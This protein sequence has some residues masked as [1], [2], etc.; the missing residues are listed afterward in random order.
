MKVFVRSSD[1]ASGEK[2]PVVAYYDD[3]SPVTA[4]AHGAGITVISI[5]PQL[6]MHERIEGE[7][8][9][10]FGTAFLSPDW[11][12]HAGPE[13]MRGEARRRA[14]MVLPPE[15]RLIA[16]YELINLMLAHGADAARWPTDAKNRL[17]DL[18]RQFDYVQ[19]VYAVA[20]TF[21]QAPVN[22]ASDSHWP[23][24]P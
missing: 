17:A 13:V 18:Q 15:Q 19:K 16:L 3:D 7:P 2:I 23:N 24:K 14:D 8:S 9:A 22:P 1:L 6:L 10:G 21:Q 20:A 11:H 5:P 12:T 4:T